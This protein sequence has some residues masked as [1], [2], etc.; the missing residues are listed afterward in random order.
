MIFRLGNR[1]P[2]LGDRRQVTNG[3]EPG[4]RDQPALRSELLEMLQAG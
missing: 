2:T 4:R 3:V 1:P